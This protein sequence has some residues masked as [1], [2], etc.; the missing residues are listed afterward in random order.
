MVLSL[1]MWLVS[2]KN[3]S[4]SFAGPR[5]LLLHYDY[6]YRKKNANACQLIIMIEKLQTVSRLSAY[7]VRHQEKRRSRLTHDN[8]VWL[9]N[10]ILAAL[11]APFVIQLS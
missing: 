5:N 2:R 10:G 6:Y 9:L 8:R 11:Y 1:H 7:F 4:F 3:L